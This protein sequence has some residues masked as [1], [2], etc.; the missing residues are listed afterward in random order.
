MNQQSLYKLIVINLINYSNGITYFIFCLIF[1]QCIT[2]IF[3]KYLQIYI[4]I[5]SIS[6]Y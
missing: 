5:I 6:G 4:F 1:K 3:R 2:F